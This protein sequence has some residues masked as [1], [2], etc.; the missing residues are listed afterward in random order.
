MIKLL[1]LLLGLVPAPKVSVRAFTPED[2]ERFRQVEQDKRK[3]EVEELAAQWVYQR[4]GCP[5][6]YVESTA[7]NAIKHHIP[8]KLIAAMV[9]VESTCRP[10]AIS[11]TGA[12]GL[13][14]IIPRWHQVSSESMMEPDRNIEVGVAFLGQLVYRYGWREGVANYNADVDKE[15]YANKVFETAGMRG[16][17]Q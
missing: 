4:Y 13:M 9:V 7:R 2:F 14:Q 11:P 16:F 8:A 5:T 6:D 17:V 12:V 1:I 3:L 15:L 10:K